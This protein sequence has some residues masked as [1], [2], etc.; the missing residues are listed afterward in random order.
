[1]SKFVDKRFYVVCDNIRSLFNVGS[2]FRIADGAG[3]DKIYLCGI[4]GTPQ[5][6][7]EKISKVALGAEKNIPWEYQNQA[8]RLIEILKKQGFGIISLEKNQ[9][10]KNLFNHKPKFPLVLVVGNEKSGVAK[11]LLKRSDAIL[12]IP[13]N[14]KKES[15]NVS[16]AS[17]IAI[18]YLSRMR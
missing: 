4:T 7:N 6:H 12:K 16:V 18:Y 1:M 5:K 15:L 14:G 9:K 17:G 10:S 13:M 2:I 3:V 11:S 8:W